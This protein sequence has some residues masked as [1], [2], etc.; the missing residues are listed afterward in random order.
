MPKREIDIDQVYREARAAD[1]STR[2]GGDKFFEH[3][4]TH[5]DI[6]WVTWFY[7]VGRNRIFDNLTPA[8][9][10]EAE[11]ITT[12]LYNEVVA[13]ICAGAGRKYLGLCLIGSI[14][15]V[16]RD[17][18]LHDLTPTQRVMRMTLAELA[19]GRRPRN[20][21][22]RKQRGA[23]GKGATI[24]FAAEQLHVSR[25]TIYKLL[26]EPRPPFGDPETGYNYLRAAMTSEK[27]LVAFTRQTKIQSWVLRHAVGKPVRPKN[28]ENIPDPKHQQPPAR[29]TNI[30]RADENG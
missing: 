11:R 26:N 6:S 15:Y 5:W 30:H 18:K 28:I 19:K 14:P 23:D 9:A 4:R 22:P 25:P 10:R 21:N 7:F 12:N 29:P 13:Q 24:T 2:A 17:G 1:F 20:A 8:E 16:K 3:V 27:H